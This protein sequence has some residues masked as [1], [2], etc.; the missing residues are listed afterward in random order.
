MATLTIK[1][2]PDELYAR[3]KTQAERHRRSLNGEAVVCLELALATDREDEATLIEE[4]RM[5]REESGVYLTD[6]YIQSAIDEGRP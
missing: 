6:D 5:L 3:L 1:N 2:I 4:L